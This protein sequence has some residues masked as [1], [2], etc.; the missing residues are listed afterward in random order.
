M[1][2]RSPQPAKATVT[3]RGR[4][5]RLFCA[6][7]EFCAGAL[8]AEDGSSVRFAGRI[9]IKEGDE[10]ELAGDWE[11]SKFGRQLKVASFQ[12]ALPFDAQ[13]LA[14]YLARNPHMKGIGP[15][16]ARAIADQFGKDFDQALQHRPEEI[17]RAAKVPVEVIQTLA[18]EWLRT[19]AFNL[20][21]TWLAA[22]DLTHHQVTT[23]VKRYGNNVVAV[24]KEDPYRLIREV[25][26]YGFKRVD[27]IAR[28][29]G[30]PK[31]H[32]SRIRGGILHTIA[33]ALDE[34][35]CWTEYEDLVEQANLLLVMDTLD[36]RDLIRAS[37]DRLIEE[38]VLTCEPVVERFLVG[39]THIHRME[40]D[41]V[42][43]FRRAQE[44]NAHFASVPDLDAVV[45]AVGPTLNAG[46][47][48]AVRSA[49]QR[50]IVVI[51]GGAG[52]GK[53]Y[54]L[55][56]ICKA[57]EKRG[58]KVVLCAPTGKAAKR[59]EES[60]GRSAQTIH[61]LLGY[62]G[63]DFRFDG[64]LDADLLAVDEM[65]MVGVPLCWHLLRAVDLS[66]TVV[67]LIG[68]RHQ[69]LPVECGAVL[70]D[71]IATKLV[72]VALLDTVVRQ[73]G[74]LKENCSGLLAGRVAPTA[75]AADAHIRPWYRVGDFT[76]PADIVAFIEGLYQTKLH[77]EFGLD[78]INEVQLLTPTRKGP[79]GVPTL[80][81]L[82][83]RLI[84]RKLYGI[85]AP[86]VPDGRRPPLLPGD[87]VIMRKNTYSL[88]LMNGSVG[89]VVSVDAKTGDVTVRFDDRLVT[90]KRSEGHLQN[91]DH[92]YALT[93][94]QSQGSEFPV[95]ITVISK[96]HWYQLSRALVYTACTR[97]KR[98]AILVGDH[99][100]M[101]SAV[102]KVDA[103]KRRTWLGLASSTATDP[104]S[105]ARRSG[106][107]LGLAG[108]GPASQ[109][110]AGAVG[111]PGRD[112]QE[113]N[114]ADVPFRDLDGFYGSGGDR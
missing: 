52:T 77:D 101:R 97:A 68:D 84:Q 81:I 31:D 9:A 1:R 88:D 48:H 5:G 111:T 99:W 16:R 11:D 35:H 29:M 17:A 89:Q 37:L 85:E 112:D 10:V 51:T 21:N 36:S 67:V 44:E 22:F 33:E 72:P 54:T 65:S 80:N 83:Q 20:A 61:R 18:E 28:K 39:Y 4:I 57:Y 42:R 102:T 73:A 45:Q 24:F 56:A 50:R 90:L 15:V 71:L 32:P 105:P 92:A 100:A 25:E 19:R 66:R 78:L 47:R 26:G 93:T 114:A 79:L 14:N 74:T 12:F 2:S 62:D 34:G 3:V 110:K 63:T 98:T 64:P 94:H 41:L 40:Q 82:L 109:G 27:Q 43:L 55:E 107:A 23:L 96:A 53:T 113:P 104:R 7:P 38:H 49:L 60:S 8:D 46:Q 95:V 6:M 91:L 76:D 86:Q 103:Q 13:G 87:K 106:A 69:L 58:L 59:M 75:P 30:T 70:R 108:L